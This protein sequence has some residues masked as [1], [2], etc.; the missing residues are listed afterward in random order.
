M[1]ATADLNGIYGILLERFGPQHW[2]PGETP[3]EVMAGAILTQNTN[4]KNVELAIGGLKAH[5]MLEPHRINAA[6]K[7]RLANVIR[8]AGFFNQKA[9]YLKGYCRYYV[10]RHGAVVG[11]MK[12]VRTRPLREELL[13]LKG[14]GPETA[15]SILLYA[16]GKPVFVIDA[17]TRRIFSRHGIL[18]ERAPYHDWQEFFTARLPRRA[19]LCNEYHALIVRL[20]KEHCRSKPDCSDCPLKD[21]KVVN[22]RKGAKVL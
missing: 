15:D 7:R 19:R 14:I 13:S 8:P 6:T 17:Y 10:S 9:E 12:A 20:A 5:G 18:H 3:F 11:R 16:L 21:L 22:V 4:W 2:W 1:R